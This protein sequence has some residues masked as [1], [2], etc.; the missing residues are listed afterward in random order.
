[1]IFLYDRFRIIS[2]SIVKLWK[3]VHCH[4]CSSHKPNAL[5][6]FCCGL[7]IKLPTDRHLEMYFRKAVIRKRSHAKLNS[8]SLSAQTENKNML[9]RPQKMGLFLSELLC[10]DFWALT[11]WKNIRLLTK[12]AEVSRWVRGSKFSHDNFNNFQN[13][14]LSGVP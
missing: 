8:N 1:M 14:N 6:F 11:F 9:S 7:K 2:K 10:I 3:T 5:D 12:S 13:P 4:L